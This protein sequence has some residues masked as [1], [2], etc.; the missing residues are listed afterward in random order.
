M[1]LA[2]APSSVAL[3]LVGAGGALMPPFTAAGGTAPYAWSLSSGLPPG[4]TAFPGPGDTCV[5][6]VAHPCPPGRFTLTLTVTDSTAAQA[7]VTF[8]VRVDRIDEPAPVTPLP[9][10][11]PAQVGGPLPAWVA[12]PWPRPRAS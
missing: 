5:V 1:P 9:G 2:I 7:S 8:D 4:V 3:L 10:Y 11:R 12:S 6:S